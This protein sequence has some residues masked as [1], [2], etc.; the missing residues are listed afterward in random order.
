MSYNTALSIVS[1]D[2]MVPSAAAREI[3]G[4]PPGSYINYVS[5]QGG[6]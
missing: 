1:A 5:G 3:T 6:V 4:Y 2:E